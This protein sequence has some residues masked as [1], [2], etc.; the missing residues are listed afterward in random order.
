VQFLKRLGLAVL[1]LGGGSV[2]SASPLLQY[3]AFDV[4]VNGSP[5]GIDAGSNLTISQAISSLSPVPGA[6]FSTGPGYG[7]FDTTNGQTPLGLGLVQINI[8]NTSAALENVEVVGWFKYAFS[9]DLGGSGYGDSSGTI[10]TPLP[11]ETWQILNYASVLNGDLVDGTDPWDPSIGTNPNNNYSALD[12]ATQP[13]GPGNP[14]CNILLGLGLS[15]NIAAGSSQNFNFL[16][17]D[18]IYGIDGSSGPGAGYTPASNGIFYLTQTNGANP[19]ETLY[20]FT[21]EPGGWILIAWGGLALLLT[22]KHHR[23]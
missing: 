7:N 17:R 15:G 4:L 16:T 1:L 2:V 20:L 9:D 22:K 13:Y 11:N 21:P 19:A 14:C 5:Y 12:S 23:R 3:W 18:S 8:A 6:V 10:G